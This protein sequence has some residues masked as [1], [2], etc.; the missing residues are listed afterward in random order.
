M[1]T[2]GLEEEV[3]VCEPL[4]PTVRSLGY[5]ARLLRQNP[6]ENYFRT[7]SNFARG[8]DLRT[9]LMSGI[10]VA[11]RIRD[12]ADGAVEELRKRRRE[13]AAAAG[14]R[15]VALGH[16]IQIDA[17]TN[18]CALQVHLGVGDDRFRVYD[19]IAY[20]LPALIYL[21]AHSP[22][23][24]GRRAGRSCRLASGYAVG[25]LCGDRYRRFQDLIISRRLK[26]IEVRAF[27]SFPDLER[28]R[29]LVA[30]L[31][32]IAGLSGRRPLDLDRYARLRRAAIGVGFD[33]ELAALIEELRR[34]AE[35]PQDMVRTVPAD[36]TA[37]FYER[38]G[39]SRTYQRLDSLYRGETSA[40]AE[41]V[42]PL[43][44]DIRLR[45]SGFLGYYVPRLPYTLYKWIRES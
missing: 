6:A 11:T 17:P 42:I 29:V 1:T 10:E 25:P 36:E 7:A 8:R 39:L 41:R 30:A 12:S 40:A 45:A 28:I 31:G 23:R 33:G 2:F 24:G 38:A 32:R 18:I 44:E 26:T 22:F 14:G 19:N 5:L 37:S 15:I 20:F 16:L 9:G 21:S 4:L 34:I 3:F 13:L 43:W 35:I 27:D